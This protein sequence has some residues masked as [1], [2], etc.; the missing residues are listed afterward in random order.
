[1]HRAP[2]ESPRWRSSRRRRSGHHTQMAQEPEWLPLRHWMPATG[3]VT[4]TCGRR[5]RSGMRITVS[6]RW[7]ARTQDVCVRG[8]VGPRS[9]CPGAI[10]RTPPRRSSPAVDGSA[11]I[12]TPYNGPQAR[13]RAL[14]AGARKATTAGA[15][16]PLTAAEHLGSAP[17]SST[18]GVARSAGHARDIGSS[19]SR[20]RPWPRADRPGPRDW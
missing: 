10:D 9:A 14:A 6:P 16:L 12:P 8:R 19:T 1:M 20:V 18:V 2:C 4:D 7:G 5:D 15:C 13:A 11:S 17:R 3:S